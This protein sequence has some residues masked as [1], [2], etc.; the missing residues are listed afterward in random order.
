MNPESEPFDS[1]R[2]KRL[3][4]VLRCQLDDPFSVL[5]QWSKHSQYSDNLD[6]QLPVAR[7]MTSGK[8]NIEMEMEIRIMCSSHGNA[9]RHRPGLL[10]CRWLWH[11]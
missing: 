10:D 4:P 11:V 2:L 7:V 1:H 6:T 8:T 5:I 3:G 9:A